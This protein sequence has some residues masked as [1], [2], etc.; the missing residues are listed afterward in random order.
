MFIESLTLRGI[1]SYREEVTIPFREGINFIAG[2]NGAGKTT[3]IE[4]IGYL[5]FWIRPYQ[6][7]DLLSTG[8]KEGFLSVTF[9]GNDERSYIISREIRKDKCKYVQLTD[10]Q[11]G[12]IIEGEDVVREQVFQIHNIFSLDHLEEMF[13]EI[14]AVTQGKF[15]APFLENGMEKKRKF[16]RMFGLETYEEAYKLSSQF[17]GILKEEIHSIENGIKNLEGQLLQKPEEEEKEK[18]LKGALEVLQQ[19]FT[20]LQTN[21]NEKEKV[22]LEQKKIKETLEKYTEDL[23]SLREN[24]KLEKGKE[25]SI[26]EQVKKSLEAKAVCDKHSN[27]HKQ[28]EETETLLGKLSA[29]LL[30]AE[31]IE[32][33]FQQLVQEETRMLTEKEG[34]EKRIL[35]IDDVVL[36][37]EKNIEKEIQEAST[38]STH[39]QEKNTLLIEQKKKLT[40][41]SDARNHLEKLLIV[42]VQ[43]EETLKKTEDEKVRLTKEI[44]K[45]SDL[46]IKRKKLKDDEEAL[47]EIQKKIEETM[48]LYTIAETKLRQF[49]IEEKTCADGEC[50]TCGTK[51]DFSVHFSTKTQIV[52]KEIH[53]LKEIQLN[54]QKELKKFEDIDERKNT[55]LK[56]EEELRILTTHLDKLSAEISTTNTDKIHEIFNE[57]EK[58]N[59]QGFQQPK[60]ISSASVKEINISLFNY[61]SKK[62]TATEQS[63]QELQLSKQSNAALLATLQARK[64]EAEKQISEK[65][66]LQK[67]IASF[68]EHHSQLDAKKQELQ[69]ELTK[70]NEIKEQHAKL[71][72]YLKTLR[73]AHSEY[74]S[75]CKEADR[76][77]DLET[78]LKAQQMLAN[79]YLESGKKAKE[80]F[81]AL[82]KTF[83]PQAFEKSQDEIGGLRAFVMKAD[84]EKKRAEQDLQVTQKRLEALYQ[85]EKERTEC[86]LEKEK[87]EKK[88]RKLEFV[89]SV[90]NQAA[91]PIATRFRTLLSDKAALFFRR[92][93][94]ESSMLSWG[95]DFEV[96]LIRQEDHIRK[97]QQL[98]GGEQMICALSIRLALM[99]YVSPF[100]IGFFDEPTQNLDEAHRRSLGNLLP[101]VLDGFEQLFLISHDD[102]FDAMTDNVIM[103]EKTEDGTKVV[104]F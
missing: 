4:S 45:F 86:I 10:L 78:S 70:F 46:A 54:L 98:S 19:D 81:D 77:P 57:I 104:T 97:F 7:K 8:M 36:H 22:F 88:L 67:K 6:Y 15:T 2:R 49:Q 63:E 48:R 35:Q 31:S 91:E 62:K 50:P 84:T 25:T 65:E 103:L 27:D 59:I 89:R 41:L 52:E 95:E 74:M 79:S 92:L 28:Y 1:K 56:N 12:K 44:S 87:K 83:D 18:S 30:K 60:K 43:E 73:S 5:L 76:L 11:T 55:L 37:P 51:G 20:K 40:S 13:Q 32:R 42:F 68:S 21:L 47:L 3:I 33:S 71:S 72:E 99:Q 100:K 29:D 16:Q 26:E 94:Q 39:L 53:E 14:V 58:L 93:S 90:L 34:I 64:S 24:Y 85:K 69:K 17:P 101:H 61:I 23:R 96:F 9:R 82:E 66:E 38:A 102:T 75:Y 80:E